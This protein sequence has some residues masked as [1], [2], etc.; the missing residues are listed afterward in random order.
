[1]L[2]QLFVIFVLM[3]AGGC[4]QSSAP[5]TT[6]QSSNTGSDSAAA[7][8]D[9]N[10]YNGKNVN[11]IV[12]TNPGGG[13]D[14]YARLIGKYLVKYLGAENIIINNIPGAG[15]I[16]GTNTLWK[17]KPDGITIGTLFTSCLSPSN[18]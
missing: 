15:H 6:N 4:E 9:P 2:K 12:T 10:F 16:V 1:M 17:S 13:Y 7:S 14:A 5:E 3:I 8:T 18:F 11:Y